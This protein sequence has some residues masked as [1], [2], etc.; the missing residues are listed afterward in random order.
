[1]IMKSTKYFAIALLAL[2]STLLSSCSGKDE[3]VELTYDVM[4]LNLFTP[5]N[6]AEDPFVTACY[7][8]FRYAVSAKDMV[9]TSENLYF[10]G[11]NHKFSTPTVPY[12]FQSYSDG[13]LISFKSAS[14]TLDGMQGAVSNLECKLSGLFYPVQ[15]QIPD[16]PTAAYAPFAVAQFVVQGKYQVSTF[17]SD[18]NYRGT[19][20]TVFDYQGNQM[21]YKSKAGSYRVIVN[22]EKK[23]ADIVLYSVKFA[24]QSPALILVLK[25]LDFQLTSGGYKITGTDIIPRQLDG[26]LLTNNESFPFEN[27]ELTTASAD[28]TQINIDYTVRNKIAEEKMGNGAKVYYKGNFKGAYLNNPDAPFNPDTPAQ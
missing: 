8:K 18:V 12:S 11:Y 24:E 20:T 2:A 25:D 7:Y 1:M 17:Q 19:T 22:V 15:K 5:L 26:S 4:T 28:L 3:D 6:Q 23:K 10:G 27:F 14:G 16:L 9:M 21:V 13:D